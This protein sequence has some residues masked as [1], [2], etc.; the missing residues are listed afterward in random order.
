MLR[1]VVVQVDKASRKGGRIIITQG[2]YQFS[3][4]VLKSNVHLLFKEGVIVTPLLN[5][6][7][8]QDMFV[9]GKEAGEN[10][11]NVTFMGEGDKTT[12]PLFTYN[13]A[14]GNQVRLFNN[15]RVVNLFV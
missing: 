12:R 9:I 7:G 2:N 11:E 4:I 1:G 10:I 15:G 5:G 3:E 13:Q 14:N 6:K 8:R